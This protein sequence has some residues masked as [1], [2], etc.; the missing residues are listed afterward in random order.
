MPETF[1]CPACGAPLD[2]R[3]S[4]STTIR[5]P[6]CNNAVIV[7]EALRSSTSEPPVANKAIAPAH[8]QE[9]VAIARSGNKIEAIKRYRQLTGV[10]L[11]EAKEAVEAL[12][13]GRPFTP[14]LAGTTS[15]GTGEDIVALVRR[16]NKLEAI[17]RYRE[18]KNVGLKEAKDAVEAMEAAQ[19]WGNLLADEGAVR[20]SPLAP[21]Q[22]A[23]I[24]ND[25]SRS[26]NCL[27]N[28]LVAIIVLA[29]LIGCLTPF[30]LFFFSPGG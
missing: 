24:A 7:P 22:P 11:K 5:C 16:G 17:K 12:A 28:V 9:I 3:A 14:A 18:Q 23:A 10:G 27:A 29:I 4:A 20:P 26:I 15:V 25:S 8:I 2:V 30:L 6:Y 1:Q 21:A 19:T 13:D